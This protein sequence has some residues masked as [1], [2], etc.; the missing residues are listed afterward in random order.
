VKTAA[1]YRLPAPTDR[2]CAAKTQ[3]FAV[4]HQNAYFRFCAD[5]AAEQAQAPAR[6]T[7]R[8][9]RLSEFLMGLGM[10]IAGDWPIECPRKSVPTAAL[11]LR[12]KSHTDQLAPSSLF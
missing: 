1:V 3:G 6:D 11:S 12:G 4:W 7:L 9:P 8:Y 5:P 10:D 2:L